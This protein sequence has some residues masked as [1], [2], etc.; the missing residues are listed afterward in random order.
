MY[1]IYA[2]R[3]N[4][5]WPQIISYLVLK[6]VKETYNLQHINPK[7]IASNH[8]YDASLSSSGGSKSLEIVLPNA[9]DRKS[10]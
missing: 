2:S 5:I 8:G 7:G 9:T 3:G 1:H 6:C 10:S 4:C